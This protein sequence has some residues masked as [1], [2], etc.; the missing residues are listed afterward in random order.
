M[1]K[2]TVYR[3][4]KLLNEANLGRIL[5]DYYDRGFIIISADRTCEAEKGIVKPEKCKPEDAQEQKEINDKNYKEMKDIVRQAGFGFVPT[6]GGYKEE[7]RDKET[8][9][10]IRD[11]NGEVQY[12]DTEQ[13]ENSLIIMA[14]PGEEVDINKLKKLGMKLSHKYNQDSFLLKPPN[15]TDK[16][17]YYLDRNGNVEMVFDDVIPNDLMQAYY[18]QLRKRRHERFTAKPKDEIQEGLYEVYIPHPPNSVA[19]AR[20]RMGEIFIRFK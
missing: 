6:L 8:G 3:E 4:W 20:K 2:S 7:L 5:T 19:E 11:E 12:V 13:P 17:A 14:R 10:L 16:D 15:N 18:T 1:K 9:E